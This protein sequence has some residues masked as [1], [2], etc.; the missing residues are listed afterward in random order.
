MSLYLRIVLVL[1]C[2][3]PATRPT[4]VAA[5]EPPVPSLDSLQRTILDA[6]TDSAAGVAL[7]EAL[8]AVQASNRFADSL[9]TLAANSRDYRVVA[10][11]SL[12]LIPSHN[13]R[14]VA[15]LIR[16]ALLPAT[17]RIERFYLLNASA[18]ILGIGDA[19][20][21]GNG[22]E[23]D[24]ATTRSARS[25]LDVADSASLYG[26]GMEHARRLQALGHADSVTKAG[27]DYGLAL[28]HQSAY[29]ICSLDLRSERLLEGFLQPQDAAVFQNVAEA[30]ALSSGED[31]IA[32]LRGREDIPPAEEQAAADKARNW[33]RTYLKE[34]AD[35]DWRPA[36][37]ATLNRVGHRT[38]PARNM[39][40]IHPETLL[41]ATRSHDR[42]ARYAAFRLLNDQYGATF[43]LD[44]VFCG[45]KYSLSFRDPEGREEANEDLLRTYW[46][47]RLAHHRAP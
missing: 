12:A 3:G 35:G 36:A 29:L 45:G 9:L 41:A 14:T 25:L 31:V 30:L 5:Q 23:L 26:L 1:G 16:R 20:L 28:W 7:E 22:G 2:V 33:W 32:P 42:L 18:Y 13:P 15:P 39:G 38:A 17:S 40:R 8:F 10:F 34:H 44:P 4:P 47:K 6:A 43:D 21:L 11:A 46:E 37:L 24:A 19:L 27:E